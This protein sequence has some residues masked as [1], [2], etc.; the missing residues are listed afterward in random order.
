MN[1]LQEMLSLNYVVNFIPSFLESTS[2]WILLIPAIVAIAVTHSVNKD[3]K[4]ED[5]TFKMKFHLGQKKYTKKEIKDYLLLK[6]KS[7]I[8]FFFEN[9]IGCYLFALFIFVFFYFYAF[10][11]TAYE[12]FIHIPLGLW[13]WTF[14]FVMIVV[15]LVFG[16]FFFKYLAEPY[17]DL[18]MI[19]Y[20]FITDKKRLSF[21]LK[22]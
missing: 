17:F 9:L 16:F 18:F 22:R 5:I 3:S 14:P 7:V 6:N 12:M 20:L 2:A 4:Y 8:K 15:F 19:P 21:Y 10:I 13:F 11:M 1:Q